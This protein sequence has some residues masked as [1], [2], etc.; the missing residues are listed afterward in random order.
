MSQGSARPSTTPCPIQLKLTDG[1]L[2]DGILY[3]LADP[4]R[5]GGVTPVELF[6]ETSRDFFVVGQQKG[7]SV[8]VARDGIRWLQMSSQGPG[9]S[10]VPETGASLDFVTLRLDSGEEVS[11]VLR[12]VAPEGFERMSD[13]INATG[14]FIVLGVGDEL[15]LVAKRHV[16]QISF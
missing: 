4:N 9:V 7:G 13:V 2:V 1:S 3:L 10:E 12:A 8:L 6:L 15:V 11:G 14:R 16:V 5:S